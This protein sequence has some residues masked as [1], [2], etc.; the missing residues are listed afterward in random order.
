MCKQGLEPGDTTSICCG[1]P[2]YLAPEIIRGEECGFSLDWWTLGVLLYEM[3]VGESPFRFVK[4]S[5]NPDQ[6]ANKNLLEVILERTIHLP[7][8]L[9]IKAATV[10]KSFLN[11][12]PVERVGCC[13]QR[14]FADVQGHP[15]FQNLNWEMMER[16]QV[17][18]P[19][20]PNMS[21]GIGLDNFD[22]QFAD[23]PVQLTPDDNDI[24]RKTDG[25]EFAGFEY[26]NRPTMYE[27]EWV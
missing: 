23:E 26:I 14:G 4:S 7:P 11:R 3:M 20:K 10:L 13:P 2:N 27:E 18:P 24:V 21:G 15:F 25:C 6:N 19:F 22:P 12:D 5:D 16:K 9:S 8:Y 1:A 17:V